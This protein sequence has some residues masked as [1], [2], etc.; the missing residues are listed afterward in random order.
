MCTRWSND[1]MGINEGGTHWTDDPMDI[2]EEGNNSAFG[3]EDKDVNDTTEIKAL[4]ACHL[5]TN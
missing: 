3:Q 1:P 4:K 2:D 5:I